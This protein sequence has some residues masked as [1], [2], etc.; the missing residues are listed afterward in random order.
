MMTRPIDL[1]G[2][3]ELDQ[4]PVLFVDQFGVLHDGGAPYP[5]VVATLKALRDAGRRVIVLSNSGRPGSHNAAR[6]S[7]LGISR[8]LYETIVTSGD[9]ALAMVRSSSTLVRA[10]SRCFVVS[11]AGDSELAGLLGLVAETD[12]AC[13]DLVLIAGSQGDRMSEHDYTSQLAP[14]ASRGIPA[15]C[16]NPDREML[17]PGGKAFGAGRIAELYEEGG[18]SVLWIGKPHTAIYAHAAHIAEVAAK[19]V[20]CIGDSV[21]H[22]IAGA[23]RFGATAALVRTGIHAGESDS[24]LS[25]LFQ[26]HD[27]IPD[28]LLKSLVW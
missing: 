24:T 10:G 11:S 7:R 9:T 8:D 13:A 18:G 28:Y 15:I 5:G 6:L 25:A 19:T 1:A 22:D 3:A 27:A 21:E 12:V 16:V 23:R 20:L 4:F 17:V 26:A 14:A 2:L